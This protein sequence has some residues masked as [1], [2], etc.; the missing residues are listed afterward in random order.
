MK[1]V[2]VKWTAWDWTL[3]LW[4]D[5]SET[6]ESVAQSWDKTLNNEMIMKL[7]NATDDDQEFMQEYR[8]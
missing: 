5:D 2:A 4:R 3:Y 6:R 1:R 8:G 7:M